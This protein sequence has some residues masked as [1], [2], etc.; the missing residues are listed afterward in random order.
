[1]VCLGG[2]LKRV[3][4]PRH[5]DNNKETRRVIFKSDTFVWIQCFF[6]PFYFSVD[7]NSCTHTCPSAVTNLGLTKSRGSIKQYKQAVDA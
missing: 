5:F 4:G 7:T 2:L 1:M 6:S 3:K